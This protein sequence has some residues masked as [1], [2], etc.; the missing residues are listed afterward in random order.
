MMSATRLLRLSLIGMTLWTVALVIPPHR[1]YAGA[2]DTVMQEDGTISL[3]AATLHQFNSKLR[4][5]GDLADTRYLV[6]LGVNSALTDTVEAGLDLSYE[7]DDYRFSGPSLSGGDSPWGDIHTLGLGGRVSYRLAP[8]WSLLAMPSLKIS[9]EEGAAWDDAVTYGGVLLLNRRFGPALTIGIG[10]G[11]F[12]NLESVTVIPLAVV[13]WQITDRLRLG[14][15]R[16]PGPTG[17]AGMELSC[18]LNDD[19]EMATG[20]AYRLSRFRLDKSG[21]APDG[22][23]EERSVPVWGRISWRLDRHLH[24]DL[25]A[26]ALLAGRVAVEDSGGHELAADRYDP[27]PL[28]SLA[29]TYRF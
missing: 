24:L 22:V 14:N 27:A 15:P 11:G 10:A 7:L 23:G 6:R 1:A 29:G 26:G 20:A 19:W 12:S 13:N 2:G 17:P 9:R 5:G 4:G 16:R 28:I 21:T 18:R 25:V 3:S 8:G